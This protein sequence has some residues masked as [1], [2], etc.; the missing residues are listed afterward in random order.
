MRIADITESPRSDISNFSRGFDD[1]KINARVQQ[2]AARKNP[3]WKKSLVKTMAA[4]GFALVGAGV[5]GAVFRNPS[6]PYVLKVY[7][8]DRGYEEWLYFMRTHRANP[9][10]PKM[11]GQIIRLNSIFSAV[12]LEILVP[13]INHD[14]A[15]EFLKPIEDAISGTY[16]ETL[17]LIAS[18]PAAGEIAKFMRDW[19][20]ASDLTSHNVMVRADGEMVIIDPIYIEPGQGYMEW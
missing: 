2:Q 15:N 19:E 7:R 17:N 8:T 6:Y 18:D 10:V 4:H 13:C 12:R 3:A 14:A 11:R 9:H 5:N 20:P 1:P 16:Q